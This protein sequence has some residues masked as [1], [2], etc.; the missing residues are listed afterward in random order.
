MPQD[1]SPPRVI[2][3]CVAMTAAIAG[4]CGW[5]FTRTDEHD[6]HANLWS[7]AWAWTSFALITVNWAV[8]HVAWLAPAPNAV[9]IFAGERSR[10][11]RHLGLVA[12]SLRV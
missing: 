10:S 11:G 5:H 6:L 9:W 1:M 3:F 12:A 2:A 4:F 8:L 7:M